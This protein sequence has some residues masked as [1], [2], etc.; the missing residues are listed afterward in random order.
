MRDCV[1]RTAN[2]EPAYRSEA[3]ER[4]HGGGREYGG[5]HESQMVLMDHPDGSIGLKLTG[6]ICFLVEVPMIKKIILQI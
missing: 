5:R 2:K 3:S 6:I 1:V 4:G